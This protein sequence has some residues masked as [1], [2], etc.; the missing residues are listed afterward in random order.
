MDSSATRI[1]ASKQQNM[2]YKLLQ[3][4]LVF[5]DTI[6]SKRYTKERLL[7]SL[8]SFAGIVAMFLMGTAACGTPSESAEPVTAS[9]SPG[10]SRGGG[11]IVDQVPISQRFRSLDDYLAFLERTQAPVDGPWYREIR[12]GVYELM[13]GNLRLVG[14]LREAKQPQKQLF[15]REQLEKEFGFTK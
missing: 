5:Q 7:A 10:A 14:P 12:P 2:V 8:T 11:A 9:S 15:T 4:R 6:V 13:T 3:M 1:A